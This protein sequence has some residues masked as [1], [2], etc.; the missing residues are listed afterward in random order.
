MA[1][2]ERS[3][4]H[5]R[6]ALRRVRPE[7]RRSSRRTAGMTRTAGSET[8]YRRLLTASTIS[9]L[10]DGVRFSALPLLA[11]A[12]LD[13]PFA[14][15]LVTAS[16]TLPWLLLSLPIGALADRCD[17]RALMVA[18]DLLRAG[19]L[20]IAVVLLLNDA[21]HLWSL[22]AVA[23]VLGIGEVLFDCA[24]FA[25]LPALVTAERLPSANG[26]L[27]TSQTL[28][29]D[30]VGHVLGGWLFGIGQFVPLLVNTVS[31]LLSAGFLSALPASRSSR[32]DTPRKLLQEIAEGIAFVARDRLMRA[33][34]LAAGLVNAVYL[35][36]IA[37]F[38]LLIR[39][40]LHVPASSYGLFVAASALGGVLGGAVADRVTRR[41]GRARALAAALAVV[42][43]CGPVIAATTSPW[44][45]G[46]ANLASGAAIMV[47]NVV[48]VS[49][50]QS[51]VPE[52]MLGRSIGVYRLFAWGTMP[53]G[54]ALYG[55]LADLWGTR[56]AFLAGSLLAV[57]ALL[58][59]VPALLSEAR[60]ARADPAV[61][62]VDQPKS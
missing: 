11:A 13:S 55:L 9:A 53:L 48:A 19:A 20:A 39:E 30:M 49:V 51:L 54:A 31:F 57:A 5:E 26:R 8:A 42:A 44:V 14:V 29:R 24:S 21:L 34:T 40:T 45:V 35:G 12:L 4:V 6:A 47:W 60:L 23:S 2:G 52:Q 37:I 50:R 28:S 43:A 59:V 22:V 16:S 62:A 17:R 56:A 58:L 38:V 25:V 36:Q 15:S 10:G 33:L 27:F 7:R 3:V 1:A 41:L 18:A 61:P 32:P 46:A